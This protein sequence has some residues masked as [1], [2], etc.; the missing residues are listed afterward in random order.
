MNTLKKVSALV[1][2]FML[3]FS[4]CMVSVSAAETEASTATVLYM[5]PGS[6]WVQDSPRYAMYLFNT[7]ENT[8]V[9]MTDADGDGYYEAEIPE[10]DWTTVIF[11]R[12]NPNKKDNKWNNKWNQTSDLAIPDDG[13]NCYLVKDGTWDKGGGE[14]TTYTPGE[15]P[16]TAETEPTTAPSYKYTVAGDA[17]LCG[18]AWTPASAENALTDEDGDGVYEIT[19]KDVPAG[20]YSFK[21]T[22]GTWNNSW[23]KGSGNY[24]INLNDTADVTIKFTESTKAI[25]VVSDGL[26]DFV[27]KHMTV[28]G[29]EGLVSAKWDPKAEE[30]VMTQDAD[31]IWNITFENVAAG[32]YEYKFIANDSY[33]YNWTVEG[34]FD[35][36]ANSIVKVDSDGA[37][38]TLT[39][40][41]SGFDFATKKG[42]VKATAAVTG[43][44]PTEP[45]EATDPT[46]STAAPSQNDYYL[47]GTINGANYGCEDDWETIGD[48]KFVDGKLSTTFDTVS[49]VAVKTG[50]N[51]GWYMTDGW[52]GIAKSVVLYSTSTLG[53]T[54][55]KLIVP[56]GKV[57]FTLVE[58]EDG[59]LTLSYE[60]ENEPEIPTEEPTTA[61]ATDPSEETTAPATTD[62]YL[63]GT[64]NGANYGCEDD[65]Q[66]IGDYKFVDGALVVNFEKDSYVGVKTGDNKSWYMTDGWAGKVSE[67]TLYNTSNLGEDADKLF[68]PAGEVTFNLVVNTDGT[69]TLSYTVKK[70]VTVNFAMPRSVSKT[71]AWGGVDLYYSKT[72]KIADATRLA[73][74]K[75]DRIIAATPD[76]SLTTMESGNLD[77]YEITLTEEQIE[78]INAAKVVGFAKP[79]SNVRTG[80]SPAYSVLKATSDGTYAATDKSIAE[81]NGN[82]FVISNCYNT[83]YENTTYTG[84]WADNCG[85]VGYEI[86][87]A[88][89]RGTTASTTWLG[90]DLYYNASA[91]SIKDAVRIPMTKTSLVI[92]AKPNSENTSLRSGE[93][94]VFTLKLTEEQI[95]AI[96]SSKLAGFAMKGSDVRTGARSGKTILNSTTEDGVFNTKKSSIK[97][98]IGKTF[99][100][101]DAYDTKYESSTYTGYWNAEGGY[102]ST[103]TA[104]IYFAAPISDK[105]TRDW[106]GVDF[107]YSV[108][109][110][111]TDATRLAMTKTDKVF[112]VDSS[113]STLKSGEWAVYKITLSAEDVNEIGSSLA[114]GFAKS[115][116]NVRTGM[117]TAYSIVNAGEDGTY[118][119]AG[120]VITDFDGKMFVINGCYDSKYET[121][122]YTGYWTS[123]DQAT[124][125]TESVTLKF[126]AP[127]NWQGVNLYYNSAATIAGAK[128]VE[129]TK[130]DATM[131]VTVSGLKTIESGDWAVYEVTLDKDQVEAIDKST[132]VGFA[133]TADSNMRTNAG[134]VAY[135][136]M[137]ATGSSYE[138]L[139]NSVIDYDGKTF[140]INGCYDP[141]YEAK[142]YIGV[143]A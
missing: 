59:S 98:F 91:A 93:W 83:A 39:I 90:A 81:F 19:Y 86:S 55:N 128:T 1:I 136:V 38:V 37:D 24:S 88:A 106:T 51:K 12:M 62:Y 42:S 71:D 120:S 44:T 9:D 28:V 48:Y 121:S 23:G 14:W 92:K 139:S 103:A 138:K 143:W 5:K 105:S 34:Y 107:Y 100:I 80:M 41:V 137:N 118:A 142:T 87:F 35:S 109:S 63:F 32:E 113:L 89:P 97:D 21:V 123:P 7:K 134:K 47:F 75:T 54:A 53:E 16:S 78:A 40:D 117:R 13:T 15:E 65:W 111:I 25:E 94:S 27:L 99:I 96:D 58:N 119:S 17:G 68:V 82:T 135:S 4:M 26:G 70:A 56:A 46:E 57:D 140:V 11:C 69:L 85:S 125:R 127:N 36:S 18:V 64:I 124:D 33:T 52:A 115:G 112:K 20:S 2:A 45:S 132:M 114:I 141:K 131:P 77:V 72:T 8:W 50:D 10:G 29:D 108:S 43:G 110:K 30:G 49:Y 66:T 84:Y 101:S 116:S 126:A 129:M 104:T 130:T 67:V 73:M 74:T 133:N 22:D 102:T 60:S 61:P 122:T 3:I 31:G 79:N 76:A 6:N 95:E